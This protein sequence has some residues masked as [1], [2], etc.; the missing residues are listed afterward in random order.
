M[1][2]LCTN[3]DFAVLTPG[4]DQNTSCNQ[5]AHQ[6]VKVLLP[7]LV[8]NYD[9]YGDDKSVWSMFVFHHYFTHI[10]HYLLKLSIN[11]NM[12]M[13]ISIVHIEMFTGR[14]AT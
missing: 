12:R 5:Q 11:I 4:S 7:I 3:L 9:F 8:P 10:I 13:K 2:R 1:E 6:F 14:I